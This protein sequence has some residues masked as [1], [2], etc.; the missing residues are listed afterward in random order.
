MNWSSDHPELIGETGK[1]DLIGAKDGQEVE[2]TAELALDDVSD[3]QVIR[4]KL[5]TDAGEEDYKRSMAGR[6]EEIIAQLMK[7][8]GTAGV[9][10]PGE[11][12]E[13]VE[14]RWFTG[15]DNNGALY[16][17]AFFTAVMIAYLKRYD[18][19]NK[20]IKE[21]EES[22]VRDLPEF[23]NKL[24]LLLNAGLVVSTA[25]SKIASDYEMLYH[26]GSPEKQRKRR[27][28]YE[29]FFEMEKRVDRSNASLIREL[30]EFSRRCGVREM[31]RMTAVI[32][33]NWDKGSTLAE[34]LEGEGELLWISRKKR[35]EEKGRLAETKLTFPL[36]ILL[37]VLIMVTIAPAM[38]EM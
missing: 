18:Q 1:V 15:N 36:M 8:G 35:A 26:T 7:T 4:L 11:L 16:A 3:I 22:I 10:L 29:E 9:R 28:L 21:A 13:G 34:K 12:G 33:D 25:F 6:L 38:L 19:I 37:L 27:Y 20:E 23:I 32:S 24:V 17:A 30:K 31:V 2:L 14:V 5:D